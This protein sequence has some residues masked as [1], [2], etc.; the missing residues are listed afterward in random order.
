MHARRCRA[1]ARQ[2]NSP[3]QTVLILF[4]GC[5]FAV[6]LSASLSSWAASTE[7]SVKRRCSDSGRRSS[8]HELPAWDLNAVDGLADDDV[9]LTDGVSFGRRPRR[10]RRLRRKSLVGKF[11][12]FSRCGRCHLPHW[13]IARKLCS[14]NSSSFVLNRLW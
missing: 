7:P 12:D 9:H 14:R 8:A 13:Q 1:R 2:Y 11:L 3:S 5:S 4:P 6:S 10:S